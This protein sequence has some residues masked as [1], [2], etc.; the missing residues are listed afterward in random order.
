VAI[1]AVYGLDLLSDTKEP[2]ATDSQ[3][4]S[5]FGSET[6]GSRR[7]WG[8]EMA[9]RRADYLRKAKSD[10]KVL[11]LKENGNVVF[12]KPYTKYT[13]L[14]KKEHPQGT[15]GIVTRLHTGLLGE[16]RRADV[17]LADGTFVRDV[18]VDYFRA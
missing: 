11:V 6:G 5:N 8:D 4:S 3:S 9:E 18:P 16:I 10:E 7:E 14:S 13:L 1:A 17:R 15:A 12:T 2:Y